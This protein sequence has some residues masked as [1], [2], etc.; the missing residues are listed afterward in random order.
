MAVLEVRVRLELAPCGCPSGLGALW[1]R[2]LSWQVA[3]VL[4]G[5]VAA[6]NASEGLSLE[7]ALSSATISLNKVSHKAKPTRVGWTEYPT[8]EE[9]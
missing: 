7:L 3:E 6:G 4:E 1:S 5:Q 2:I 8:P 9:P